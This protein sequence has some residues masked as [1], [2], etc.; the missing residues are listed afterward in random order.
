MTG[1]VSSVS[2][3]PDKRIY[4]SS[5][6]IIHKYYVR[7]YSATQP[8]TVRGNIRSNQNQTPS[9]NIAEH[10]EGHTVWGPSWVLITAYNIRPPPQIIATVPLNSAQPTAVTT[11]VPFELTRRLNGALPN[12]GAD[13]EMFARVLR[14]WTVRLYE[15]TLTLPQQIPFTN[16]K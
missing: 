7:A 4:G 2:S 16:S 8:L 3:R 12:R 14:I 10:K 15:L 13:Q 5:Y 9:V 1:S 11:G 6:V